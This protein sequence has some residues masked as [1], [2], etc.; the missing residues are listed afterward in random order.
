MSNSESS[1]EWE[2]RYNIKSKLGKGSFGTV[3]DGIDTET[4]NSVAIKIDENPNLRRLEQEYKF[5]TLLQGKKGIPKVF[6]YD[7]SGEKDILIM[8]RLGPSLESLSQYCNRELDIPTIANVG[9]QMISILE[10]IHD[11]GILHR[12]IKPDNFLVGLGSDSDDLF[13]IDFGLARRFINSNKQTHIPYRNSIGMVGNLRFASLR[14]Q[15]GI[16][17]G[18]RDDLES[19]IYTLIYLVK[20]N[21]PWQNLP[22]IPGG[23]KDMRGKRILKIKQTLSFQDICDECPEI[24]Q[25]LLE[26]CRLLEFKERPNYEYLKTELKKLIPS[27]WDGISTWRRLARN[28][29]QKNT[30]N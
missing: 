30:N 29:R 21:L 28:R 5:Y 13:L 25:T 17:Q 8:Q 16:E 7:D 19:V 14:A 10:I 23:G 20:G 18:R 2:I 1:S 11:T 12:D 27:N 6:L 4:N 24:F 22:L 15:K 26:Y 9:V 3:Y